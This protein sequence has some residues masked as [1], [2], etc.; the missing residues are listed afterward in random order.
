MTDFLERTFL[1]EIVRQCVFAD[2]AAGD[3][4]LW[5]RPENIAQAGGIDRVWYSVQGLLI[6]LGNLSKLLWPRELHKERDLSLAEQSERSA[7]SERR[8]RLRE[9]LGVADNSPLRS[10]QLRNVFEH[11]DTELERRVRKNPQ[12]I[13]YP[14]SNVEPIDFLL[15][16]DPARFA[17]NLDPDLWTLTFLEKPPLNLGDALEEVARI[18]SKSADLL[19]IPIAPSP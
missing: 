11:I 13:P 14:D 8:A 2:I 19:S 18:Y 4:N 3:L 5:T 10:V 6:S 15:G 17:R 12:P 16:F 7:R 9:A 1:H